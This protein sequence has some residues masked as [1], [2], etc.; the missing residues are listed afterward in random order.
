MME[1]DELDQHGRMYGFDLLA[2]RSTKD[3]TLYIARIRRKEGYNAGQSF[4]SQRLEI[5]CCID[6]QVLIQPI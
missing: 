3:Y 2:K 5:E 6:S 4:Q 1:I